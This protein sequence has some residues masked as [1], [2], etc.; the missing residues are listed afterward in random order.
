MADPSTEILIIGAGPTG[1]TLALELSIHRIPF[2]IIDSLA[3]RS[4]YSRALAFQPRSLE[5]LAKHGV[6]E[7]LIS[8]GRFNEAIRIFVAKKFVYEID[9]QN[10]G[11]EDTRI[12][13]PLMISQANTEE[14][15]EEKLNEYGTAAVERGVTLE[16]LE[17]DSAGVTALLRNANGEK[18]EVKVRYVIG[19]DGAHS[20]VRKQA[21]LRF[22]GGAYEQDFIL[23]DVKL[24]W[25]GRMCL[26]L[27][28]GLGKPPYLSP[29][30][31]QRQ[32]RRHEKLQIKPGGRT[33]A[34]R[35][36]RSLQTTRPF[37]LLPVLPNLARQFPSPP[38]PRLLFP[39][40]IRTDLPR[41]RRSTYSFPCRRA[42]Y[43]YRDPGLH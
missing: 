23:A 19:C 7:K 20:I 31:R 12:K 24:E 2:R 15:M 42:R 22:E 41:R 21:S 37:P 5:L 11:Y 18:E 43:E 14:I 6:T 33:D 27:H 4:Q 17:E 30:V 8:R 40:P 36:R 32:T 3:A 29:S 39:L 28:G 13:T 1:L 10:I 34:C 38:P 9:I 25:D 35:F 16:K 26:S